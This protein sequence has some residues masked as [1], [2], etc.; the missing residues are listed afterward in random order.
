MTTIGL[1]TTSWGQSHNAPPLLLA[2]SKKDLPLL[3]SLAKK[4]IYLDTQLKGELTD[5]FL[6][7]Q[8]VPY[9]HIRQ[10]KN[11]MMNTFIIVNKPLPPQIYACPLEKALPTLSSLARNRIYLGTHL[12]EEPTDL[13]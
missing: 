6:R 5:L 9:S 10:S 4:R 8:G 7:Y 12:K 2:P 1:M 3:F 13:F 11:R